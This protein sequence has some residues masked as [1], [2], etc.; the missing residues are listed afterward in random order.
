MK[1]HNKAFTLLEVMLTIVVLGFLMGGL[2]SFL[3]NLEARRDE[4]QRLSN[5][6]RAVSFMF[7]TLERDI[8]TCVASAAG[9]SGV[10]GDATSLN[11]YWRGLTP[12]DPGQQT[13]FSDL[14]TTSISFTQSSRTL[15]FTRHDPVS[16]SSPQQITSGFE[17]IRI[18]Y[19]D[20]NTWQSSF[21]SQ[22]AGSLPSAIEIAIWFNLNPDTQ[23]PFEADFAT[24]DQTLLPESSSDID[25]AFMDEDPFDLDDLASLL[26]SE[27]DQPPDRLRVIA[28]PDAAPSTSQTARQPAG[29]SSRRGL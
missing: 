18:R 4:L 17:R 12:I 8:F 25:D 6:S 14:G 5:T 26:D 20:G 2:F 3:W 15:S 29:D 9:H 11:I 21:D 24:T 13:T 10:Q 7:D 27:D 1:I 16:T 19:Y 23:S 22:A 28:I